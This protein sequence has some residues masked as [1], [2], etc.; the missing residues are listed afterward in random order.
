M[1][2]FDF[3]FGLVNKNGQREHGGGRWTPQRQRTGTY[4]IRFDRKF[5]NRPSIT[6]TAQD[7]LDVVKTVLIDPSTTNTREFVNVKIL[8]ASGNRIDSD[9][10]FTAVAED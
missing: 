8:D 6:V 10:F 3:A 5:D 2:D 7:Q 4:S 9:F 1:A